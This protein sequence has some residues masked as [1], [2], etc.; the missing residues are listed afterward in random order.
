[1]LKITILAVG[2]LKEPHWRDA[3][4]EFLTRLSPLA[5]LEVVEAPAEPITASFGPKQSID[6]EGEGLLKRIPENATA[7][8]LVVD[9][10][11]LS[12]ERL[13]S[14]LADLDEAGAP[15]CFVVG[16][17]AGLSKTV[18]ERANRKLSLSPMTLTHEMARLLL[19]EQIYRGLTINTGKKYH[20]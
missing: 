9:G 19:L 15:V 4:K 1:M 10:K 8:A 20:Y 2:P 13:A 12:S 6:K 5:K 18:L 7:I 14:E 11:A 16:G 3:Q 17:A